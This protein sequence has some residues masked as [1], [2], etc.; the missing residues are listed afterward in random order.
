M[1]DINTH[2]KEVRKDY[3]SA[4]LLEKDLNT[5]P[6]LQ[7]ESWMKQAVSD[8]ADHANA[9][10]LS[11][12]GADKFPDARVVLLR[13]VSLGGFTFFTNYLSKKGKDLEYCPAAT[14]L[15][16]WPGS[17]RQV[18]I[19]GTIQI[20]PEKYS[21]DYFSSRPFESQV[22]AHASLQSSIISS[23]EN[24]D[25]NFCEALKKFKQSESVPRPANWGGYVLLP[26]RI[27][28]WQGR[29]NRLHDRIQYLR[30]DTAGE[31]TIQRLMP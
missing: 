17:E 23:R 15:F 16:F 9:M 12:C 24:L 11:T 3:Q 7:F 1:S 30:K 5:D 25:L 14:L 28:F 19:T 27:E 2:I 29:I 21:D 31:W 20:L 8:D 13:D 22:G 4:E 6:F 26:I 18:R 10:V